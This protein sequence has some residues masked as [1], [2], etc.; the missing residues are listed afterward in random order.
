MKK[1]QFI[2][3]LAFSSSLLAQ[4]PTYQQK[5]YYTCKVWGFV[6]YYHSRVSVCQVNWDSVLIHCLPLVKS[7]VTKNDFNDALDTMLNAA[8]PMAL[9][10]SPPCDT[11][12]PM[13]KRNLRTA[14]INDPTIFRNDVITILDTINNN[15][16]PHTE[17]SVEINPNE[18]DGGFLYFPSGDTLMLN[19]NA[20]TNYPD[21]WHRLLE[22][23]I[24]WNI[25]NYFN[26][27]N[28]L[29]NE[30]WDSTLYNTIMPLDQ[31]ANDEQFYYAFRR[32]T[33]QNVDAHTEGGTGDGYCN[34]PG[35]V[36]AWYSPYLMLK[37]IPNQYVVIKSQVTGISV[38]D[39]IV[40]IN[41]LTTKQW[42]DSLRNYVS[43]GDTA[44]FRRFVS[45]YMLYGNSGAPCTI[46]YL[47]SLNNSHTV[48]AHC[49]QDCYANYL[50]IWDYVNGY[51]PNDTL[52]SA[53]YKL[54]SDCNVGYV[55]MGE[56]QST[57]VNNMY[58]ALQ[59]TSAII[60]DLRDYPNGTAWPISDLMYPNFMNNAKFMIPDPTYPG[61]GYWYY[62]GNG[63]NGNPT[64]Y[65]GKVILLFNEVT[66]SQGEFSCMMLGAMP[67]VTKIGSQ[68][69]GTDGDVTYYRLN[70][71]TQ[72]MFTTLNTYY[73][74]GDSTERVGIIPDSIIYPTRKGL[75]HKRDEVLEKALEVVGCPTSVPII[76]ESNPIV[77]VY[78]NPASSQIT[79][80]ISS[81]E[82]KWVRIIDETGRQIQTGAIY[83]NA[84]Q[85]NTI[86]YPAGIYFYEVVDKS[87][88]VVDR[89][90]FSVVR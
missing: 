4:N 67:N 74:N 34:F 8:G 75:Y 13:L 62:Q 32:M 76:K 61:T 28:Y 51:F 63:I 64:P 2:L 84:A 6:K 86:A 42:E 73:P 58:S 20:Y 41:G 10:T 59:N 33:A 48:V 1:L 44:V 40:S 77:K 7:A 88:R 82:N 29:H 16:R 83:N 36:N 43:A 5:L 15:F 66:Q 65:L 70:L 21:E 27:Y 22:V 26:P 49:N 69:A 57:D 79:F 39:A 55:N 14:W 87:N 81:G 53:T 72:T 24:H 25:I 47:D 54:W 89:G 45:S 23:F 68:T 56:L 17:C 52:K 37:Y 19:V 3:L 78:P 11:M 12:P 80:E 85:L 38:G 71:Y 50:S 18:A 9:T 60:F 30:P 35:G 90:K 46:D 31:A